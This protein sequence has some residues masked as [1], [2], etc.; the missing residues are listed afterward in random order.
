[1][2]RWLRAGLEG[3]AARAAGVPTMQTTP[4]LR[5]LLGSLV[6][7]LAAPAAMA[8]PGA[9]V[10]A[11]ANDTIVC[12]TAPHS[13]S[14]TSHDVDV[15]VHQ[16]CSATAHAD[17]HTVVAVCGGWSTGDLVPGALDAEATLE[18]DCTATLDLSA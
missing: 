17:T 5:M 10:N 16:D 9:T 12:Q 6:L 14:P 13:F 15:E 8:T 18:K 2:R 11:D 1:M 3:P 4:I 7:L